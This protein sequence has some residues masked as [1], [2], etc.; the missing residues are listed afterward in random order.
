[1]C[2]ASLL[3]AWFLLLLSGVSIGKIVSQIAICC[4]ITG[5]SDRTHHSPGVNLRF[6][7]FRFDFSP[8]GLAAR[9]LVH[10]GMV[11]SSATGTKKCVSFG[12]LLAG[13]AVLHFP[14]GIAALWMERLC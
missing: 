11:L 14:F 1:M 4:T 2:R 7:F 10:A 9:A 12:G 6:P 13:H 5:A 3:A 8:A